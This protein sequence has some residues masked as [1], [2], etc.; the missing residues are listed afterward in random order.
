M[1]FSKHCWLLLYW[2]LLLL[3]NKYHW[4]NPFWLN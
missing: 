2:L 1:L 4:F 3:I